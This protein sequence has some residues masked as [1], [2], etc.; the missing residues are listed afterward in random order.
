MNS[1]S[2]TFSILSLLLFIVSCEKNEGDAPVQEQL[3]VSSAVTSF[4]ATV[5]GGFGDAVASQDMLSGLCGVLY[6]T[7]K[8]ATDA[9][10]SWAEG[11]DNANCQVY[12][13][14]RVSSDGSLTSQIEKLKPETTYSYC[15]FYKSK[16]GKKRAVSQTGTFTTKPFNPEVITA[17]AD[18]VR[19]FN[20]RLNGRIKVDAEDLK[21]CKTGM[22]LSDN[23]NELSAGTVFDAN[24]IASD[25][26]FT[27]SFSQLNPS[28]DYYYRTY[29]YVEHIDYKSYG[30]IKSVKT[31]NVDDM[32]V[33]MGL[34]VKWASCD[35]MAQA[36]EEDGECYA[37]GMSESFRK[38]SI[39]DYKYYSNGSYINIGQS[40]C[41]NP[42]YDVVTQVYG[43]KWRMP[44]NSEV[45]ELFE[46]SSLEIV[47][48]TGQNYNSILFKAK[49][50][51]SV[52]ISAMAKWFSTDGYSSTGKTTIRWTGTMSET[53]DD[54]AYVF[55]TGG[56]EYKPLA[57][58]RYQELSIRP[59]CDY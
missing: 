48:E 3:P 18:E 26:S 11:N 14:A 7:G 29:L 9:F 57:V 21:L 15:L 24:E 40:I 58:K 42:D 41:G 27:A 19:Y 52:K 10:K 33:D 36:P 32:A 54:K 13:R 5:S 39:D 44:S 23:R 1:K 6:S 28:T 34:S 49:N 53:E 45:K 12:S 37:W 16:S 22:M 47:Q 38:G 20:A 56:L 30:E 59:V 31:R 4:T 2:L 43:G 55:Q 25:G 35:F 50:G 46:N 8:D 51:A 17:D